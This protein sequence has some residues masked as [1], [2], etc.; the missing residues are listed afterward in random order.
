MR[1]FAVAALT[2]LALATPSA[3]R[4][5]VGGIPQRAGGIFGRNNRDDEAKSAPVI[6]NPLNLMIMHR[7]DLA[8][9]DSQFVRIV[10]LK[11]TA[12]SANVPLMRRLDSL[13]RAQRPST[14][15]TVARADEERI[16]DLRAEARE[17]VKEI[18]ANLQPAR[19]RAFELLNSLQAARAG[20]LESEARARADAAAAP[21]GRGR[22]ARPPA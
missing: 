7:A 4:A 6:V 22:G 17:T 16:R 18:Y 20:T 8:L 9:T 13:Q 21:P 15:P 2:T 12:D 19:D 10:A 3:A 14:D 1:A 11:R 5:Q